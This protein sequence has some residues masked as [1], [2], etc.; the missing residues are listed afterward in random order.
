[1]CKFD[2]ST[3]L[4]SSSVSPLCAAKTWSVF[5]SRN[6]LVQRI[7]FFSSV[8]LRIAR[9][10]VY[11]RDTAYSVAANILSPDCFWFCTVWTVSRVGSTSSAVT[12]IWLWWSSFPAP[13]ASCVEN[14]DHTCD[15]TARC[16]GETASKGAAVFLSLSSSSNL[17][18][19]VIILNSALPRMGCS[20]LQEWLWELSLKSDTVWWNSERGLFGRGVGPV[21]TLKRKGKFSVFLS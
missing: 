17:K 11:V 12:S 13:A 10:Q 5:L 1:M 6:C 20:F 14:A 21:L 19:R 18:Y 4:V 2:F 3:I 9:R 16:P 15:G 7:F 8:F